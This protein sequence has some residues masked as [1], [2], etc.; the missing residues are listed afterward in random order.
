[1]PLDLFSPVNL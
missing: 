1:M